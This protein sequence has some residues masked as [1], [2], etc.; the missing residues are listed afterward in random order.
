MASDFFRFNMALLLRLRL[1]NLLM[2]VGLF[3]ACGAWYV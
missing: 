1:L 3:A 2:I